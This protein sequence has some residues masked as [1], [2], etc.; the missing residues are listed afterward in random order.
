MSSWK[1]ENKKKLSSIE[2]KEQWLSLK[3]KWIEAEFGLNNAYN[4]TLLNTA[5]YS[6]NT[7]YIYNKQQAIE[8]M[9]KNIN[10]I[11]NDS[12]FWIQ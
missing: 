5:F 3:C 4:S 9:Y 2:I 6:I 7:G 11:R 8:G 10:A 12:V 1:K